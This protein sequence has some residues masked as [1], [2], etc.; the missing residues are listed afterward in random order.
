MSASNAN[1]FEGPAGQIPVVNTQG[2]IY[3]EV[4]I[5]AAGQTVFTLATFQYTP[6]TKTIIV[7]KNGVELRR[8][9]GYT[10]TD[11]THVTLAAGAALNDVITFRAYA[12]GTLTA[13]LQNNGV[14][15]AGTVGQ[16]LTK[17]SNSDYD[18]KWLSLSSIA[19]LLD[20]PR[21][22]VASA[23]TV[24][25]T[26]LAAST[27]NIQ[28]TGTTQI[29]GWAITNGQVFVV[30]FAASLTLSNNAN[31]VTPNGAAIK[32]GPGD[33]CLVR[34]TADN[35]V[36][37]LSFVKS[38]AVV[39]PYYADHRL[40]VIS[41]NP[42]ADVAPGTVCSTLYYTAY[43]GNNISLF[44]GSS[45]VIRQFTEISTVFSVA[46]VGRP[47]DIFCYDNAGV[48]TLYPLAWTNDTTRASNL[49]KQDGVWVLQGDTTKRYIGTVYTTAA[50]SIEDSQSN[51]Y[52]WNMYNRVPR[53]LYKQGNAASWTIPAGAIRQA[54]ASAANQ[55]NVVVGLLEDA[56]TIGVNTAVN[57]AAASDGY[58]GIGVNSNTAFAASRYFLVNNGMALPL[59]CEHAQVLSFGKNILTWLEKSNINNIQT[60]G[61]IDG[62]LIGTALA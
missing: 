14:I 47:Y 60:Y 35:V 22:N 19:T 27:R 20:Q 46:A 33:S 3:E 1:I 2:N 40:T 15:P 21:V 49:L 8:A 54:N 45:W 32:V 55:V 42:V 43:K 31:Q 51:R 39:P 59:F 41:G 52:V 25:L 37:I 17:N 5:A 48:A 50:N 10:E 16:V 53:Q 6:G 13:P 9:V 38:T 56:V 62:Y 12:I 58:I 18:L 34:A 61:S 44:N 7:L 36:E 11:S 26:G 4:Q 29:D 57:Q 28:I 23:P 30:K 24:D